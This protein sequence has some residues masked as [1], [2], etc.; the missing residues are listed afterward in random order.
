MNKVSS[1]WVH[2]WSTGIYIQ[3]KK[4]THTHTHA[5]PNTHTT[6]A[7]KSPFVPSWTMRKN[8]TCSPVAFLLILL[9]FCL[10][11][12]IICI[13]SKTGAWGKLNQA[14]SGETEAPRHARELGEVFLSMGQGGTH[15]CQWGPLGPL[16]VIWYCVWDFACHACNPCPPSLPLSFFITSH[17]QCLS[18]LARTL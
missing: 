13:T 7:K 16:G 8:V 9:V 6:K 3:I 17:R 11:Y 14:A 2:T 10:N 5:H 18:A 12:W 1:C 4:Y 15:L